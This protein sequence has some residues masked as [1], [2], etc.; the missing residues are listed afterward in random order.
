M[1]PALLLMAR[2]W[3]GQLAEQPGRL[4][5]A[6]SAVAV[7]VTLGL[8]IWLVNQAALAEFDRALA[9]V[10]GDADAQVLA[11][12][13]GFDE[14]VYPR[15]VAD[16]DVWAASPI[17]DVTV[18]AE[19][20]TGPG[21]RLRVIGIDVMRAA[22]VT[23]DLVPSPAPHA[24]VGGASPHFRD[25]AIFV[26]AP[27]LDALGLRVGDRLR[28]RAGA[29]DLSLRIDGTLASER[30]IAVMD[31]GAAQW[32]L[33]W[34]GRLSRIDL[35]LRKG[36]ALA[37]VRTRI[38]GLASDLVVA[39]PDAASRRMSNLSRAYRVNLTVLALVSLLTGGFIVFA[40]LD[41]AVRRQQPQLALL[42]TLG[43]PRRL[44]VASV[45][46]Q[47]AAVGATGGIVGALAAVG[48]A[49][50][51][52]DTLGADLGAGM[53]DSA[54][55]SIEQPQRA[56]LAFVVLG[57]AA[58]MA[59]ALRPALSLRRL[60]PAQAIRSSGDTGTAGRPL[61]AP[62]FAVAA[63]VAGAALLL[64]PPVAGLPLAAYL[65]ILCWLAAAVALVEPAL[66]AMAP[67]AAAAAV[68]CW[69][70][71]ALHLA[72]QRPSQQ[73]SSAAAAV[74]GVVASFALASAMTIMVHSFRS[75]VQ[76]WLLVVLPADLYGRAP[77]GGVAGPLGAEAR[78]RIEAT[79][80]VASVRFLRAVPLTLAEERAPVTL[81]ARDL[82]DEPIA[83]QLPLT[84]SIV[85]AP[86]GCIAVYASEAAAALYGFAAGRRIALPVGTVGDCFAVV[87]V[88]R[89]YARQSGAI[90][91]ARSDYARASGDDSSTDMAITLADGTDGADVRATS[92]IARLHAEVPA[93][94]QFEF[95]TAGRIR[96]LSI[97]IFDRSFAATHALEIAAILVALFGVA[98]AYAGEA[99]ARAR[100]FGL[101]RHLGLTRRQAIGMM[102]S[103][104]GLV[105]AVGVT[106]GGIAGLAIAQILI[107]RVNPQ[108]FHWTMSVTYPMAALAAGALAMVVSGAAAG[109]AGA[110]QAA[111]RAPLRAV[112]D[113][114]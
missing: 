28:L 1:H 39:A 57:I 76:S 110:R 109:A 24:P 71:P 54:S 102:A 50:Y 9:A 35:R 34:L 27:A 4:A 22:I 94:R 100:E 99:F 19:P 21:Q 63:V 26:S 107:L 104:A 55:A 33:G 14:R 47:G 114:W 2:W 96:A 56:I 74:A 93:T 73:A 95:R 10:N 111:G 113:D 83:G 78:A 20:P 45:L 82:D 90:V 70:L 98:A 7:G 89:D 11:R 31:I 23:P 15:I 48:L 51:L 44:L 60:W 5:V 91:I 30:P 68:R 69:R 77:P 101:L 106:L 86:E 84:G 17:V 43:A 41:L 62:A 40:T 81:L 64:A 12:A 85:P 67:L 112:R 18:L 88:W 72:V 32:R 8:A 46:G 103:E 36:A 61:A 58:G 6:A 79:P 13:F 16:P 49:H 59:G 80:G 52:L 108:S 87:G 105:V 66:R 25:D 3:R 42:A 97:Q 75:A 53:F 29:E 38:E 37:Q 65:A 92:V